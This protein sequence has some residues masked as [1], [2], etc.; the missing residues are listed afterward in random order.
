MA[1]W[2]LTITAQPLEMAYWHG[3][4]MGIDRWI[5]GADSAVSDKAH[6]EK[7]SFR[8]AAIPDCGSENSRGYLTG[9]L[10]PSAWNMPNDKTL[11]PD[12][13][14]GIFN[15]LLLAN[16]MGVGKAG[17]VMGIPARTISGW[18]QA[19]NNRSINAAAWRLL[20]LSPFYE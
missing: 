6:T 7:M 10:I 9:Y 13:K 20:L 2:R 19:G 4:T 12:E 16:N 15:R 11:S 5:N 8:G 18:R 1:E 14:L 3:V 17:Q